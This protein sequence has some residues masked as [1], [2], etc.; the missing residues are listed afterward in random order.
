MESKFDNEWNIWYHN[1]KED[2]S[3][4]GYKKLYNIANIKDYWKLYNNWDELGTINSKHFFI[5]KDN[6]TPIWEDKNNKEGGC[7]SIKIPVEKSFELWIKLSMYIIGETLTGATS[8]ATHDLR[9]IDEDPLDDGFA[10]N[11]EIETAAD[12]ILDFTEANP[13]I[14]TSKLL[15][16]DK[17]I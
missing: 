2:W 1:S 6:I 16:S 10:D 17:D 5:M 14:E 13:L 12:D 15:K 9:L 4:N 11:T 3:I 8:G 7:W